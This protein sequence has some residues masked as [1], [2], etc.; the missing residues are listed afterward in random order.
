MDQPVATWAA[1]CGPA[2]MVRPELYQALA[3][4]VA[5]V[6]EQQPLVEMPQAL[7]PVQ[8][9]QQAV[10]TELPEP[11]MLSQQLQL[12]RVAVALVYEERQLTAQ[13]APVAPDKTAVCAGLILSL[14]LSHNRPSAAVAVPGWRLERSDITVVRRA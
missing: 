4:A 12:P 8:V 7:Q 3:A 13:V 6:P 11:A 9:V 10:E 1:R 14:I 5:A 2:V